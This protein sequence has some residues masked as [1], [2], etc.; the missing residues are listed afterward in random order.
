MV[1]VQFWCHFGV[2]LVTFW[3]HFGTLGGSFGDPGPSQ[4]T[5]EGP[6][7]KSHE[8]VDFW[9]PF[10][11][12][13]GCLWGAFFDDFCVLGDVFSSDFSNAIFGRP[14][15]SLGIPSNHENSGFA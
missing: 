1:L 8:K 9:S 13:K 6:S 3:C 5:S 15:E 10:G 14:L 11:R 2:I 12:P 7:R 4:G